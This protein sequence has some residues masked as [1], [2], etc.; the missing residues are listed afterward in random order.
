MSTEE[1]PYACP[2]RCASGATY[3]GEFLIDT[4]PSYYASMS[5]PSF[6]FHCEE[7][8]A[9]LHVN[10][11]SSHESQTWYTHLRGPEIIPK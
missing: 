6:L 4:G 3:W 10:R 8:G 2:N 1:T 5:A 7:C 9:V 11:H